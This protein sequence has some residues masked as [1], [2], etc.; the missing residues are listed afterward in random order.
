MDFFE[1]Q[2]VLV[3]S[4]HQD[5]ETIGCGGIIQKFIKHGS[6]VF[7]AFGTMVQGTYKKFDKRVGEYIEYTGEQRLEETYYALRT[8]GVDTSNMIVLYKPELHHRLDTVPLIDL[9]KP[10]ES[11]V[12]EFK[13]TIM[14]I[15][16]KSLNQDHEAL[17]RACL[18][19]ARPHFF[20]GV[21][22]EYEIANEFDFVPNFYVSLNDEELWKKL[23]A[24]KCYKTQLSGELHKVSVEGIQNLSEYRGRET[25]TKYAEAFCIRRVCVK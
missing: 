14:L 15:P 18:I 5:D 10:I 24:I 13:P 25:Y 20:S 11:V 9:V 19:V 8:L 23:E 6:E 4:A 21:V 3:I 22:L 1:N 7:I 12:K 2:R 17:H 16:A